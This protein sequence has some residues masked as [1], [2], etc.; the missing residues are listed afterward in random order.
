MKT[1]YFIA[2][3]SILSSFHGTNSIAAELSAP[4]AFNE[5]RVAEILA[6]NDRFPLLIDNKSDYSDDQVYIAIV[7]AGAPDE[8]LTNG[9]WFDIKHQSVMPMS[10]GDNTMNGPSSY[11]GN[12][13]F[14]NIWTKVSDISDG[15][16]EIPHLNSAKMFVAFANPLYIHFH[17]TGG[18]AAPDLNNPTDPSTGIR[19]ETIEL[20]TTG[21]NVSN[22]IWINTTRV[23]A[24]Q[25]PMGLEVYGKDVGREGQ[26]YKK[27][28]ELLNHDEIIAAWKKT[29]STPFQACYQENLGIIKQPSKIADFSE[30]GQYA[31]YFDNYVTSIWNYY[32]THTLKT[33]IGDGGSW[34]GRVINHEMVL[35]GPTGE[36]AKI[37]SKPTTQEVIEAKGALAQDVP[38]TPST[39]AD[40]VIQSQFSAAIQRGVFDTAKEYQDWGNEA[41]YYKNKTHNEYAA[42]FHNPAISYHSETYAFSYDDVFNHS[43]TIHATY[44]E[45]IRLTIG[46]FAN[47]T[48]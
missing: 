9:V 22:G 14:A 8:G 29:V 1:T 7:A 39:S 27:V 30:G 40:L 24:Y 31:G 28:G 44:P 37:A 5:Q 15:L 16:I 2:L 48:K 25:Y 32:K 26:T 4:R 38:S 21:Y 36:I 23:D 46:G 3:C 11:H 47:V 13:K 34:E 33:N 43:S 18:Y 12:W 6:T 35:T 45:K 20:N 19:F 41:G 17:E 10:Y 42:F